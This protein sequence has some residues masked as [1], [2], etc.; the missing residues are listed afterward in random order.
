MLGYGTLL[1]S[2]F[3]GHHRESSPNS[4]AVGV[5]GGV[6]WSCEVRARRVDGLSRLPIWEVTCLG[7]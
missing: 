5:G 4:R 7:S 2:T 1:F 6:L 3:E